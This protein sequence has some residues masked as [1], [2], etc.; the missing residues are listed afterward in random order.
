VIPFDEYLSLK[1]LLSDPE[2]LADYLD[3]LHIQQVKQ[4]DTQRYSLDEVKD[5]LGLDA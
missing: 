2:R 1:E 3:Y 4:Q 5:Q